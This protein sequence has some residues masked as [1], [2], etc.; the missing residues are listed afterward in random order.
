MII[1]VGITAGQ[2]RTALLIGGQ[3]Q[4]TGPTRLAL[5]ARDKRMVS[6]IMK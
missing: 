4:D 1:H 5:G 3:Q 6:A 2:Y